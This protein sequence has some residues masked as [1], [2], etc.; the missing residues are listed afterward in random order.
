MQQLTSDEAI[1][2]GT[3]LVRAALLDGVALSASLDE[4]ILALGRVTF[5]NVTHCVW[6]G[7]VMKVW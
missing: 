6:S 4:E 3:G 2:I 5:R 1:E 7:N